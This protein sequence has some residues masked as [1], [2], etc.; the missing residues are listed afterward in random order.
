MPFFRAGSI[1]IATLKLGDIGFPFSLAREGGKTH[2]VRNE[3]KIV[4]GV[5]NHKAGASEAEYLHIK[6]ADGADSGLNFRPDMPMRLNILFDKPF[7]AC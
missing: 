7:I 3:I 1:R 6:N 2:I 5:H 4:N